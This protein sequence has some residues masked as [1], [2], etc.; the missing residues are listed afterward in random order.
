MPR[1]TNARQHDFIS[2][3]IKILNNHQETLQKDGFES[4]KHL[5]E[6]T[7]LQEISEN[8]RQKQV[9]LQAAALEATHKAQSSLKQAYQKASNMVDLLTGILGKDHEMVRQIKKMR[10]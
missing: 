1:L 10:K 4:I 5:R 7:E 3:M 8:D 2:Q 9:Q 6:L